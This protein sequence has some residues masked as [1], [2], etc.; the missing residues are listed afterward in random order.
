MPTKERKLASFIST[1]IAATDGL[2]VPTAFRQWAA[3]SLLSAAVEQRVWVTTGRPSRPL[4]PNQYIFL[5]A[6]PGVGKTRIIN[7]GRRL[8]HDL[9][10]LFM[11]PVSMTFA[12]L[13]DALGKAKREIIRQPEGSSTYNSLYITADELGAFMHKYEPEMIDGLSAFYDATPY[14]QERRTGDLK[15][16]IQSPQLNVIA[17]STPQNLMSFL[18]ERAWGQGFTSRIIMVFSDERLRVDDFG[19]HEGGSMADLLGD[20]KTIATLYGAF[21]VTP[22]YKDAVNTWRDGGEA[23]VPAHPRLTHYATRRRVHVYKLSMV[24]SLDRDNGLAL[25]EADFFT[26]LG[27]LVDAERSMDDIFKAGV[28]NSDAAA[29]DDIVHY[30]K[31]NDLGVGVSEQLIVHYAQERIPITSILRIIEI[32][33]TSGRIFPHHRDRFGA[34]FFSVTKPKIPILAVIPKG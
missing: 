26:A 16:K 1:F 13:V 14:S 9:S 20:L 29:I 21:H 18:P 6:H 4:Y 11:A 17:G 32:M 2:G 30:V 28:T 25:T 15:I 27:W 34:R 10:T 12:S 22:K 24:A 3:I 31:I 8:A 23:P 19:D 5:V 7:E 33:E